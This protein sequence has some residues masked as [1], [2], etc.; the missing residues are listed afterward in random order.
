MHCVL[1][2]EAREH[3]TRQKTKPTDHQAI[4][5]E[6][7]LRSPTRARTGVG[8]SGKRV[9]KIPKPTTVP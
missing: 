8:A 4:H 1:L 9:Q 6:G 3:R 2:S 7:L 5:R